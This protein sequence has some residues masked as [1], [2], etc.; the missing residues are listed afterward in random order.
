M[1]DPTMLPDG[2]ETWLKADIS[3]PRSTQDFIN[4]VW[5]CRKQPVYALR[6]TELE[7][8]QSHTLKGWLWRFAMRLL[9]YSRPTDLSVQANLEGT[10]AL[11]GTFAGD[12]SVVTESERSMEH[13]LTIAA[14]WPADPEKVMSAPVPDDSAASTLCD[15]SDFTPRPYRK[16]AKRRTTKKRK[17]RKNK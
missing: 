5:M 13:Y 8:L 9:R 7:I 15:S 2:P 16:P 14:K 11:P 6:P 10:S 12:P 3:K 4:D 1:I 17:P